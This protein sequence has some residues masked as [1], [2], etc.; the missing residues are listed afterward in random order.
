[1]THPV[2][3]CQYAATARRLPADMAF[4]LVAT[5]LSNDEDADDPLIPLLGMVGD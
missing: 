3:R 2:V 5:L 1:M 4:A